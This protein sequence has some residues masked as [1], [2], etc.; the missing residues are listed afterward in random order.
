MRPIKLGKNLFLAS[1]RHTDAPVRHQHLSGIR[2]A[3]EPDLDL[4]TIPAILLGVGEQIHDHLRQRVPIAFHQNR[5]IRG[6]TFELIFIRLEMRPERLARLPHQRGQ[7]TFLKG[8]L[9]FASLQPREIQDVI[10][11]SRQPRRFVRNR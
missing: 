3:L 11:Q 2:L 5:P 8:V 1:L 10:D 6:F 4:L 7:I 9:L